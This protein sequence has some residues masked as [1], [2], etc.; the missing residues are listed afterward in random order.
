MTI[1]SS[2]TA[3]GLETRSLFPIVGVRRRPAPNNS[4]VTVHPTV[5]PNDITLYTKLQSKPQNDWKVAPQ[6]RIARFSFDPGG[7][8][9]PPVAS[10]GLMLQRCTSVF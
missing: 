9:L 3:R 7:L 5:A 8:E 2:N 1:R 6:T 10:F 4:D